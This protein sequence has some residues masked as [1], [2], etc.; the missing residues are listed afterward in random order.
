MPP[1]ALT[2][3]SEAL[4]VAQPHA[5]LAEH[6][7]AVEDSRPVDLGQGMAEGCQVGRPLDLQGRGLRQP[8]LD[9]RTRLSTGSIDEQGADAEGSEVVDRERQQGRE[10]GRRHRRPRRS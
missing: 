9:R 4:L 8:L 6:S 3:R 5:E 1:S 7:V 10:H 2:F